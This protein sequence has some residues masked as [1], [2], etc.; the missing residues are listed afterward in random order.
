MLEI[1]FNLTK[2]N[3]SWCAKIHQ[4][5]SDIL[6]R[7][8]LRKLQSACYLIDFKYCEKTHSGSILCDSGSKLGSFT[9]K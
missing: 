5:N 8:I 3:I 1:E 4:L 2:P 9:I 6:R 7:H